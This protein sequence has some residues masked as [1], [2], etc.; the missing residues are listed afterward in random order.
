MCSMFLDLKYHPR[1]TDSPLCLTVPNCFEHSV[2]FS[3]AFS[4]IKHLYLKANLVAVGKK[5]YNM[6]IFIN[7]I[8]I[9]SSQKTKKPRSINNST[10]G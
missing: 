7:N 9:I 1:H 3:V 8:Y 4:N 6:P 5:K 2:N 10:I